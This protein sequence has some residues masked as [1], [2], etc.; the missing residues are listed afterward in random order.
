[1]AAG[2]LLR[3]LDGPPN[4]LSQVL[5]LLRAAGVEAPET[6]TLGQGDR[7]LLALHRAVTAHDVEVSAACTA[8][9]ALNAATL[10]EGDVG[11][12]TPR[13]APLGSGGGLRQPTYA[14]LEDLPLDEVAGPAEL[15]RRCTVGEPARPADAD[16]FALVDDALAGP[17]ELACAECG[18]RVLIDLDVQRLVLERLVRWRRAIDVEVHLIARAYHW[19][20]EEIDALE[21]ERRSLLA[22][23]IAEGT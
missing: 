18:A 19:A 12:P 13:W 6:L 23:L 15:L 3:S 5:A 1:M 4:E 2:A 20:L 22:G 7:R 21:D 14:D 17:L 10:R 8:C 16:D 11:E 9:G